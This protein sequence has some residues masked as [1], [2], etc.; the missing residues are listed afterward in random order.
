[1]PY[2]SPL[3]A[4]RTYSVSAPRYPRESRARVVFRHRQGRPP[5]HPHH[6]CARAKLLLA[7]TRT[8]AIVAGV[9]GAKPK[10]PRDDLRRLMFQ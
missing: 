9:S 8:Y 5:T 7:D 1:M 10:P 4:E 6:G 3:N 2:S